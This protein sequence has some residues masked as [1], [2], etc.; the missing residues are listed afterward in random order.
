MIKK[1]I[2]QQEKQMDF[3]LEVGRRCDKIYPLRDR[4]FRRILRRISAYEGGKGYGIL[5]FE[6]MERA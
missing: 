5:F 4:I 1:M 2:K 3:M 6:R